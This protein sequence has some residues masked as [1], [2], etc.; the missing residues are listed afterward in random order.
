MLSDGSAA[1]RARGHDTYCRDIRTAAHHPEQDIP[2]VRDGQ[3][4]CQSSRGSRYE[5]SP[6]RLPSAA[7]LPP[8]H[9]PDACGHAGVGGRRCDCR[10]PPPGR[11]DG[12]FIGRACRA[13]LVCVAQVGWPRFEPG[14]RAPRT[15]RQH[16]EP[17]FRH[18]SVA[19]QD[20]HRSSPAGR[21]DP[22]ASHLGRIALRSIGAATRRWTHH[23]QTLRGRERPPHQ[24]H[25]IPCRA[26][27][28]GST[29]RPRLRAALPSARWAGPEDLRDRRPALWREEGLSAAHRRRRLWRALHADARTAGHRRAVRP[30]VRHRPLRG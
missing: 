21:R 16:R 3:G 23:R 20:R 2:A 5:K 26:F 22:D 11:A 29:W 10:R 27:A 17:V 8:Q 4:S 24:D 9:Q 12:R 28:R 6:H 1:R 25:S 30:G 19:R 15:G 18:C 14:R 13:R 7:V